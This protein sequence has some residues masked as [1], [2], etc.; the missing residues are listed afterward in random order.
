MAAT[1]NILNRTPGSGTKTRFYTPKSYTEYSR[2]NHVE[3]PPIAPTHSPNQLFFRE[4]ELF[5][6]LTIIQFIQLIQYVLFF[7]IKLVSHSQ[8]VKQFVKQFVYSIKNVSIK[9]Y[10]TKPRTSQLEY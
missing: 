7:C 3:S 9:I 2:Q 6:I 1:L 10:S 8:N 5:A 4:F